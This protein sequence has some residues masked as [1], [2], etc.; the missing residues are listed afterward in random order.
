MMPAPRGTRI[1][2]S[3]MQEISVLPHS[4]GN[5]ESA[6]IYNIDNFH[7]HSYTT[8]RARLLEAGYFWI[9]NSAV[10]VVRAIALDS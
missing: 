6:C 5:T 2:V 8:S 9:W 7:F 4:A 1:P 10:S 3:S